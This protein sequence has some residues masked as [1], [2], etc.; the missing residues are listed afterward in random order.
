[1]TL[2]LLQLNPDLLDSSRQ[3]VVSPGD[4][5]ACLNSHGL[6][7]SFQFVL[8]LSPEVHRRIAALPD[9]IVT[10][11]LD[12]DNVQAFST[13][14]HETIHWW[15]HVGSTSGLLMSLS[16]PAQA[17]A[18]YDQLKN[19]V[20][21]IGP[22]KSILRLVET[23][24]LLGS[25]DPTTPAGLANIILNNYFDI[26][27]FRR[28]LTSAGA[29]R[30]TVENPLF[31]SVGH[32]YYIAY[33][34]ILLILASTLDKN[35]EIVPDPKNWAQPF[36]EL[37]AQKERGY[38]YGSNVTVPPLAA[39]DIFEGQAR[40]GQLQYLHFAS[41]KRFDWDDAHSKGMLNGI[42][43]SAFKA[44]LQL[45]EVDWPSSIDDPTV[46]LFM[47]VCDVAINPSAGFPMRL[48][49]F[50]T[51]IEDVNPAIRF[52]FLCRTI[53]VR[54]PDVARAI[55]YYSR[56]EYAEVAHALCRPLLLDPPLAVAETVTRWMRDSQ[57]IKSL[58]AEHQSFDYG[59]ANL[60]VRLLFSHFLAFSAD[61]FTQPEVFCWPGAWMAGRRVS[62]QIAALFERHSALFV[63]K[64]DDDGVFPRVF[65]DKDEANVHR[66]FETFYAFN[67]SYEL[68]RQ[69]IAK[70]GPFEYNFRWLSTS[71]TQ[72][73]LKSFGDRHFQMIYGVH[74]DS[75]QV[76]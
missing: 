5:N 34:N 19:L 69:W 29:V 20:A 27:S 32:S 41:G 68:T 13:Y 7:N 67:V 9:G 64:P 14:L 12:F 47:L 35:F 23:R 24:A 43:G 57:N 25:G 36:A 72:E 53:A 3:S 61:K 22:K 33:A 48:H 16:Y 54:R 70:A 38:Y 10:G 49:V 59:P 63:D 58:M 6:Y 37:R 50:K 31:D 2:P 62:L 66:T 52:L 55:R 18:N 1:M 39:H 40:F 46:A 26:E 21:A 76:I 11:P 73:D 51:F 75:V 56:S 4:L 74:P 17:H 45:A 65:P 44:F 60:P 30:E 8:R 15:Q 42:Y 71:A 28:L